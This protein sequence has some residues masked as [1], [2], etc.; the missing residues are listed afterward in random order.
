MQCPNCHTLLYRSHRADWMKRLRF[1]R[2]YY[3]TLCKRK[4]LRL[5]WRDD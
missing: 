1:L 5:Q 3:C 4:F 2:L